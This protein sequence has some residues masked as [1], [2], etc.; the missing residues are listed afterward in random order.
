MNLCYICEDNL[1]EVNT[2]LK[3]VILILV[4]G[5]ILVY[6]KKLF[7]YIS[8]IPFADVYDLNELE[9]SK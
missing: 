2:K 3:K 9:L 8:I 5:E 6:S 4:N 1:Q 7:K